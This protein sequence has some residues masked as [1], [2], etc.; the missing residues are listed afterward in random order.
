MNLQENKCN[1]K[2]DPV[3]VVGSAALASEVFPPLSLF[4]LSQLSA[5]GFVWTYNMAF[6]G[7]I[8]E[9]CV[10]EKL[11]DLRP[12][13]FS[14]I[15]SQSGSGITS[16]ARSLSRLSFP[17]SHRTLRLYSL[18]KGLN[19]LDGTVDRN[20]PDFL[21]CVCVRAGASVC[22]CVCVCVYVCV[23]VCVCV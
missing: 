12:L 7:T 4:V 22:E 6:L 19:I 10:R 13:Y 14:H 16:Y 15:H 20:S 18:D 23:C 11:L 3:K 17:L 9:I 21:V 5:F 1:C 2:C 8:R